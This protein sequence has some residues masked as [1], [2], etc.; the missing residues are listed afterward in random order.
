MSKSQHGIVLKLVEQNVIQENESIEPADDYTFFSASC[1]SHI[2]T[3]R[4]HDKIM[5]ANKLFKSLAKLKYFGI[6]VTNQNYTHLEI[7]RRFNLGNPH[8]H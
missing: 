3:N 4:M 7:K 1:I 5:T 2:I 8:Y 6:K